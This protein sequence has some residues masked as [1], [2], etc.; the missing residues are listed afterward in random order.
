M[1]TKEAIEQL[2]TSTAKV[3]QIEVGGFTYI[4]TPSHIGLKKIEPARPEP[5]QVSSLQGVVEYLKQAGP[6][7]VIGVGETGNRLMVHIPAYNGVRVLSGLDKIHQSRRCYVTAAVPGN[8]FAF[9]RFMPVETFI[10]SVM[11]NFVETL[12]RQEVL[13]FVSSLQ[14]DEQDKTEDDGVSQ[15]VLVKKSVTTVGSAVVP[16]P[17]ELQPYVTFPDID[18]P[19]QTY[20][21]RI[22]KQKDQPITCALFEVASR[23]WEISTVYEIRNYFRAKVPD[24]I[25]IS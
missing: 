5:L 15:R 12:P 13:A 10:I 6:A 3:E 11:A 24:V 17:V 19:T 21:F 9:D 1:L 20:V 14:A 7:S 16:N 23:T 4:A 25:V 2:Q 18:Q 8:C 22:K